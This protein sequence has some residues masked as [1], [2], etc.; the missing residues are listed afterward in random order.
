[1]K[2][3]VFLVGKGSPMHSHTN[4]GHECIAFGGIYQTIICTLYYTCSS[5]LSDLNEMS[6]GIKDY[7]YLIYE[8]NAMTY[9]EQSILGS[10]NRYGV[11]LV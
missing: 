11:K 6:I 2:E 3:H 10:I 8:Q 4:T 9:P 1:M 5:I 7:I